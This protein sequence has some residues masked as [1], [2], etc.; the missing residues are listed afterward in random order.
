VVR[1]LAKIQRLAKEELNAEMI[2]VISP[3]AYQYSDREST[4]NWERDAYTALGPHV[5]APFTFFEEK[6]KQG[7]PYRVISLL[8]AFQRATAF[9]LYRS[10]DP[11]WNPAG[12]DLVARTLLAD[13]RDGTLPCE[14]RKP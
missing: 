9:P 7:L 6:E 4:E 10:D 11:H 5:L 8:P 3:R 13:L 12:A 1:N 14:A 2:L